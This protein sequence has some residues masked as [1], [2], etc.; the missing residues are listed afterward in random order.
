MPRIPEEELARIKRD[1]SLLDLARSQG[2]ALKKQGKDYVMLCPFHEENTPSMLINEAKNV[3][4]CFGCGAGG[5]VIDWVME[6]QKVSFLHAVEILRADHPTLEA[7]RGY[8]NKRSVKRSQLTH[9]E[10]LCPSDADAQTALMEVVTYYHET[11]KKSPEAM[12]Y[13]EKRGLVHLDLVSTFK[14]G[15]CNQ[16]LGYRLPPTYQQSGKQI[17][18]TLKQVGMLREKTGKEHFMGSLVVPVFDKTGRVVECYGRK[19][20]ADNKL[21][22]GQP[23]HLYLPGAHQGVFNASCFS[24]PSVILCESMMDAMTFWVHG[25]KHVTCSYG[26]GGFT[27]EMLNALKDNNTEKLL[28]AYDNDEAGNQSA[29]ALASR[30]SV[31]IPTLGCYRV[32]FPQGQDA[33]SYALK[34]KPAQKALERVLAQAQAMSA[35]ADRLEQ[36]ATQVP[37]VVNEEA[38]PSLVLDAQVSDSDITLTIGHRVYRVRGLDKNLSYGQL[39]VNVLAQLAGDEG[40]LHVDTFDLY[41]N[42][43]RQ[44]Y[45]ALVAHELGM[46]AD[47]IKKDLGQVLLKLE[48]L[49]D[50]HIKQTLSPD[51]NTAPELAEADKQSALSLLKSPD[52]MDQIKQDFGALGVVGEDSNLL[53]GYLASVSRKLDKPLAVLIQSSSSAGKSRVMDAVLSL[54]PEEE[55]VQYSALTG[56]S[57]FYMGETNL[58]HK[59]LAI[60][61]EEGA[62]NASYALKLLQSEGEITIAS[63]GK[64]EST[65]NLV[66]KE[67]RVEG[68][69]MLFLTTTAIDIDEELLNRCLVLSV[70]ESRAQTQAIQVQQRQ[71]QTLES[72]L[73]QV[74]QGRIKSRHQNAQRMLKPLMVVNPYAQQLG[75]MDHQTRTRRD[76]M[77]YLTLIRTITLLHQYQREVKEVLHHGEVYQY[78]ETSLSDIRLANELAYELLGRT[79]DELPP[80]TRKLLKLVYEWVQQVCKSEG[81]SPSDYRFSR[82][83]VRGMSGWGDTQLKVHLSRLV[84]LEYLGVH[85]G[86]RHQSWRYELLYGGERWGDGVLSGL[87]DPDELVTDGERSGLDAQRSGYGR[88]EVG[89]Q[90]GV[91]R[92]D[93]TAS[94]PVFAKGKADGVGVCETS[95][96]LG[97][98]SPAVVR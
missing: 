13:L 46:E 31:A 87:I 9:L 66:T 34:V 78:I 65:G 47:R 11:L 74:D 35:C 23:R 8:K 24:Q 28:I 44:Q 27:D 10:P 26:T 22:K 76:H 30:L 75:F 55:R 64:D 68:P 80:Q 86:S 88:P 3:Y 84:E 37:H 49:Q 33:N 43:S 50:K 79:L 39:K 94:S 92:V 6:T 40:K 29:Q 5:N 7:G 77:K 58:K 38:K 98:T 67:Y 60:A 69:V 54:M 96:L 62:S 48:A 20:L 61:E 14:L 56:Q 85:T 21:R 57:L 16:T 82:K 89:V 42:K 59:I 91:G 41:Q 93:K 4:H 45:I 90:S 36:M 95:R 15:Y 2:Y 19:L 25:F 71:S 51:T 12:A 73:Q 17:R 18:Q 81:L 32:V 70:N 72:L 53:V 83:D 1:V 52:L 97:D 63:T